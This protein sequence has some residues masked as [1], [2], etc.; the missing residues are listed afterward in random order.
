MGQFQDVELG[1]VVGLVLLELDHVLVSLACRQPRAVD[2]DTVYYQAVIRSP[3]DLVPKVRSARF[4]A[5]LSFC[6][7]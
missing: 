1:I 2:A 3:I 7:F 5:T 6:N 4:S